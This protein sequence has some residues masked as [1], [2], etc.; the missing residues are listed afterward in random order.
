MNKRLEQIGSYQIVKQIGQGGMAVVYLARTQDGREV[1]IKVIRREFAAAKRYVKRFK[2]E[3]TAVSGLRHPNIIKLESYGIHEGYPYAVMEYLTGE[4][5]QDRL[6]EKSTLKAKEVL[7]LAPPLIE[8]CAYYGAKG[9]VHRDLKPSNIL[10][11]TD[12]T[13]VIVDFGLVYDAE[14][15][16]MT[17]SGQ[18][19]GTPAYLAPEILRG[20]SADIRSDLYQFGVIFF[21]CLAGEL[22]FVAPTPALVMTCILQGRARSLLD[23]LPK[24]DKNLAF[25]IERLMAAKLD[26]RY[27]SP[28]EALIDLKRIQS[29]QKLQG[30]AKVEKKPEP[31]K[32]QQPRATKGNRRFLLSVTLTILAILFCLH[33]FSGDAQRGKETI[34]PRPRVTAGFEKIRI[35]WVS[36]S[37]LRTRAILYGPGDTEILSRSDGAPTFQHSFLL[38]VRDRK[39]THRVRLMV[40]PNGPVSLPQSVKLRHL[41]PTGIKDVSFGLNGLSISL[42]TKKQAELLYLLKVRDTN[43]RISEAAAQETTSALVATIEGTGPD[44]ARLS[45]N[46]KN[47]TTKE[48]KEILLDGEFQK[49]ARD[50]YNKCKDLSFTNIMASMLTKAVAELVSRADR[51]LKAVSSEGVIEEDG[52]R[53]LTRAQQEKLQSRLLGIQKWSREQKW[54]SLILDI[55]RHQDVLLSSPLIPLAQ[56]SILF[57]SAEGAVGIDAGFL[58]RNWPPFTDKKYSF[59]RNWS[60]AWRWS[61]PSGGR[62]MALKTFTLNGKKAR[63]KATDLALLVIG[64]KK[65]ILELPISIPANALSNVNRGCICLEVTRFPEKLY[66]DLH[67][68]GKPRFIVPCTKGREGSWFCQNFPAELLHEGA[69]TITITANLVSAFF[70]EKKHAQVNK[71]T[72]LVER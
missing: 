71:V 39:A 3:C 62:W 19:V 24:M 60:F 14:L 46:I 29:G 36:K 33:V 59:G 18:V 31:I 69:N 32:Q 30:T 20:K 51:D 35:E 48:S 17:Q 44:I 58:A 66:L 64:K 10:L 42:D 12:G 41:S 16:K 15:T 45:L 49:W 53:K 61:P 63:F 50:Y 21:E 54:G 37:A 13:P 7:A 26:E 22:P 70:R 56:Q 5:L 4:S 27:A 38:P 40:L 8:A 23:L 65:S 28:E 6:D 52:W 57:Q 1:A 25:F 34:I 11:R 67:I 55:A 2:R 47:E 43:G 72:L 9:L 68:N